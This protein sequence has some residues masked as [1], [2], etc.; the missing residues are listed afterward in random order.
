MLNRQWL[1]GVVLI[2]WFVLSPLQHLAVIMILCFVGWFMFS[3]YVGLISG[4]ACASLIIFNHIG[5]I[6]GLGILLSHPVRL[7]IIGC[8]ISELIVKNDIHL[9]IASSLMKWFKPSTE[10][11][12]STVL[13]I[14]SGFLSMWISNTSAVAMLIPVVLQLGKTLN[15]PVSSLLLSIAYGSTMGGMLTPIGTPA[16]LVAIAYA[17]RYFGIQLNFVSWFIH[18][19]PFVL[20]L[21]ICMMVYVYMASDRQKFSYESEVISVDLPQLKIIFGLLIC[22]I[23]WATQSIWSS[24]IG[25]TIFEE[26][27]GLAFLIS[28]SFI[29]Y[30]DHQAFHWTDMRLISLSSIALVS[31]GIFMAD[32]LMGYE[33]IDVLMAGIHENT[34]FEN[35]QV[36]SF[37]GFSISMMT[38]LCSNT[39]VTSLALPLSSV[40]VQISS[41]DIISC[42]LLIT[43]SANSAFMLPT[44]TPPNAL[45]LGTGQISSRRLILTGFMLSLCSLG[46][47]IVL[48]A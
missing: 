5:L 25:F 37:F 6:Q 21:S 15:I 23:L 29:M 47:L 35:Y 1:L 46:I 14:S 11:G 24:W 26:W 12:L 39:A 43:L 18:T 45:V 16:N 38:E 19:F 4:L 9:L 10:F 44:A 22:I 31:T 27:I 7:L 48:F 8:L 2:S 40:M 36:L 3:E 17:Q 34:L 13:F 28:C 41:L 20:M 32:A 30:K 33:V 42:L